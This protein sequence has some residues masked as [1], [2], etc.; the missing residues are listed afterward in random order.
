MALSNF[1]IAVKEIFI[2]N[3][4]LG[5]GYILSPIMGFLLIKYGRKSKRWKEFLIMLGIFFMLNFV[6]FTLI[7]FRN[8]LS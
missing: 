5:L 6:L 7:I 8:I 4:W 1:I 2:R 3:F